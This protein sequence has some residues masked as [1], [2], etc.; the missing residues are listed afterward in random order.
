MEFIMITIIVQCT[1]KPLYS[2]IYFC[3]STPNLGNDSVFTYDTF[4][5][6][7]ALVVRIL[8]IK[9]IH[10]FLNNEQISCNN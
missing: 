8:T 2:K 6:K 9:D 3:A 1:Y 7:G 4:N 10:N 5:Y